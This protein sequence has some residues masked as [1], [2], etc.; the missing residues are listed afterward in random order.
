MPIWPGGCRRTGGGGESGVEGGEG[1]RLDMKQQSHSCV[2]AGGHKHMSL[3]DSLPISLTLSPSLAH[4]KQ[5]VLAFG[6]HAY[7][8]G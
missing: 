5:I 8:T 4:E 3:F 7:Q 1:R 6:L 2:L